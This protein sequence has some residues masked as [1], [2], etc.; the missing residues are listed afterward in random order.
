MVYTI[1]I[2]CIL[3]S[4]GIYKVYTIHIHCTLNFYFFY[5]FV[6]YCWEPMT[7]VSTRQ[8]IHQYILS[9]TDMY[10]VCTG[11]YPVFETEN[12]ALVQDTVLVVP[13][14]PYSIEE[15]H[16]DVA[17]EDCWAARPSSSSPATCA[18]WVEECQRP[19]VTKLGWSSYTNHPRHRVSTWPRPRTW[20]AE[21]P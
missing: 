8:C 19:A 3:H 9:H 12:V 16:H 2:P 5:F 6:F 21:S 10:S 20:W 4:A 17:L 1:H 15:D 18:Q 7:W 11:M 14:Y 13:P